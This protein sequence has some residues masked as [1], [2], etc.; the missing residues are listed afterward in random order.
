MPKKKTLIALRKELRSA[1]AYLAEI[2]LAVANN[3][4]WLGR[5]LA[6]GLSG[7]KKRSLAELLEFISN[8][9]GGAYKDSKVR[10]RLVDSDG[11]IESL[12]HV[13]GSS[14]AAFP[15][16][17]APSIDAL[18]YRFPVHEKGR[19]PE[20]AMTPKLLSRCYESNNYFALLEPYDITKHSELFEGEA[21]VASVAVIPLVGSTGVIGLVAI[22]STDIARFLPGQG[23]DFLE[24]LAALSALAIENQIISSRLR[25]TSLIDPLTGLFNRRYLDARLL[26]EISRAIDEKESLACLVIDADYFKKI[27]DTLGHPCGDAVLQEMSRRIRM[28]IKSRDIAAR[29]GGEEFVVIARLPS[30]GAAVELAERIRIAISSAVVRGPAKE[31]VAITA[32]VGGCWAPDTALVG[33]PNAIGITLIEKADA[34][35]YEAKDNGRNCVRVRDIIQLAST[36][37]NLV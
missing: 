12:L 7:L 23:T 11:E 6:M 32:S 10:L 21:R 25:R 28:V 3:E 19:P 1:K 4:N 20:P 5:L 2:T 22:G 37:E 17:L 33:D 15:G 8:E 16:V 34:A 27:N 14:A 18:G 29:F 36:P 30:K 31:T 26:E 35:L 13:Y 24:L 9:F